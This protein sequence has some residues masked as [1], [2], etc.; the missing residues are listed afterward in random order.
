[1]TDKIRSQ[2]NEHDTPPGGSWT[3]NISVSTQKLFCGFRALVE[4][5]A[6]WPNPPLAKASSDRKQRA[7]SQRD[8]AT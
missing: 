5:G 3:T 8:V 1:M 7:S 6:L 2:W 4:V